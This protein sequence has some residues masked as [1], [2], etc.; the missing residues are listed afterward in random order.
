MLTGAMVLAVALSQKMRQTLED[1]TF[2]AIESGT[3]V[4]EE[5]QLENGEWFKVYIQPLGLLGM[6]AF[7]SELFVVQ[8]NGPRCVYACRFRYRGAFLR[9][10][11]YIVDGGNG[12]QYGSFDEM[13]EQTGILKS[14][15]EGQSSRWLTILDFSFAAFFISLFAVVIRLKARSRSAWKCAALW[16]YCVIGL[17]LLGLFYLL[18][19]YEAMTRLTC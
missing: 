1:R 14:L 13:W 19:L 10:L 7:N 17:V 8:S 5:F 11:R 2:R 9:V 12:K 6:L 3:V 18:W 4:C 15:S 16:P